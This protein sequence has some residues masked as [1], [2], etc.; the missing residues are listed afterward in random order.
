MIK[1]AN[2]H[3]NLIS[4]ATPFKHDQTISNITFVCSKAEVAGKVEN[5]AIDVIIHII[6]NR[7]LN[8]KENKTKQNKK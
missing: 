2:T 7:V 1:I 4:F 3:K 5:D 6:G 8:N